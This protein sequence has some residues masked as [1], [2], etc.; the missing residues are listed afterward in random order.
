MKA[1]WIGRT[2]CG[3]ALLLLLVLGAATP[4]EGWGDLESARKIFRNAKRTC[5]YYYVISDGKTPDA[6]GV[7]ATPKRIHFG[8][9]PDHGA[10]VR[11]RIDD[12]QRG[13]GLAGGDNDP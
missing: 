12:A 13:A 6:Y 11:H 7:Q 10:E 1:G 2:S 9:H 5:E 4:A 3:A 8:A